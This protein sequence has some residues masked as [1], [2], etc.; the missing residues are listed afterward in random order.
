MKHTEFMKL[1]P[2]ATRAHLPERYRQFRIPQARWVCQICYGQDIRIHYEVSRPWTKKGQQLEIAL[3]F[4]S[5]NRQQ[6]WQLLE[7]LDAYRFEMQSQLQQEVWA[8]M[9]DRGWTKLYI[10]LPDEELSETWLQVVAQ[11]WAQF[12]AVVQPIFASL[13]QEG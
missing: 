9:W 6:N 1:L 4:E 2:A 5:R 10:L 12:I 13:Q 3:H 11:H 7:A 8:E